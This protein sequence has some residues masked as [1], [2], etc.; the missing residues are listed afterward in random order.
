MIVHIEVAAKPVRPASAVGR[1]Q[2]TLQR[3]LRDRFGPLRSPTRWMISPVVAVTL[4]LGV[5]CGSSEPPPGDS[6]GVCGPADQPAPVHCIGRFDENSRFIWPGSAIVARMTGTQVSIRF[7]E[8]QG[9]NYFEVVID[10]EVRP[11]LHTRAGD[12]TYALGENLA[13]GAHDVSVTRRTESRFGITRFLGF[14]GATL[15][16]TNGHERLIE[17]VGDSI[18]CGYGVL[19]ASPSCRFSADTEAETYAW[20]ALAGAAVGADVVAIAQSGKGLLR[21]RP[22]DTSDP[23]PKRFER[24][25]PDDETSQWTFVTT[26][27]VVVIALGTNDFVD[28]DPGQ[29]F[30][31]AYED[32]LTQIRGHY[33][34]AWILLAGSPMLLADAHAKHAAYVEQT[35]AAMA[36]R[37]DKRVATVEIAEQSSDDGLGCDYHPG[38]ATQRK[39]AD[40]L[41]AAIRTHVGW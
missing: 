39:M 31:A 26:P 10:G 1:P 30:V 35:A 5:S 18:T 15:V 7:D 20:G 25:F 37:G 2:R 29:P 4:C 19:G 12:R 8:T 33:P 13:A 14:A 21:N 41:L 36:A 17:I 32:F 38:R 16:S 40:A 24:I 34:Q 11:V 6:I 27:D 23:M 3:P 9:G 22:G 28:G